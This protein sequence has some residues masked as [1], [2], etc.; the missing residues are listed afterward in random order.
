MVFFI[1]CFCK[2]GVGDEGEKRKMEYLENRNWKQIKAKLNAEASIIWTPQKF[3]KPL[4]WAGLHSE[5]RQHK[6]VL[7]EWLPKEE[8]TQ[9]CKWV[10]TPS[11]Q[12]R[13]EGGG[14]RQ[15]L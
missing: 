11:V 7:S 5:W 4:C 12:S 8:S 15:S 3:L 1:W 14:R 9:G 13:E 6:D 2:G 10:P